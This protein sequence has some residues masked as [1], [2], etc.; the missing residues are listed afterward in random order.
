MTRAPGRYQATIRR[1]FRSMV[2]TFLFAGCLAALLIG[3]GFLWW[4]NNLPEA[5]VPMRSKA[6]GIVVLTGSRFRINDA[7]ELLAAGHGRRLLISGVYPATKLSEIAHMMPEFERWFVCC[8]DLDHM[9]LNTIGNAVETKRWARE[10]RSK[11]LIVVTSNFHMPRALT[12]ISHQLPDVRL[13]AYP[14]VSDRVKIDSWWSNPATARLLFTEY[15]K[16]M[17]ASVR[18][19]FDGTA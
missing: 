6:D 3:V 2:R 7:L 14:V 9:A 15:L 1:S 12:E 4:V 8:V 13:V 19:R 10:Q 18:V 5:E 16:Y 17:V 11:S